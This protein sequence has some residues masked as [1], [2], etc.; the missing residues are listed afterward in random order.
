M[1]NPL[2]WGDL[3]AKRLLFLCRSTNDLSYDMQFPSVL[4]LLS[5][6][7][8]KEASLGFLKD[9]SF[10]ARKLQLFRELLS[11]AHPDHEKDRPCHSIFC[12]VEEEIAK[13]LQQLE[14]DDLSRGLPV[15]SSA[16]RVEVLR[17]FHNAATLFRTCV[18]RL[19]L[20]EVRSATLRITCEFENLPVFPSTSKQMNE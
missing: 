18:E 8:A 10:A 1:L 17:K 19:E 6:F 4:A 3:V 20:V 2:H 5:Y 12:S 9:P 14:F 11:P 7:S 13:T 16:K 15:G